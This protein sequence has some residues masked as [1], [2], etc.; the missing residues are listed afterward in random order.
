M[1]AS[2]IAA[3][4][5]VQTGSYVHAEVPN[6]IQEDPKYLDTEDEYNYPLKV[7]C[8]KCGWTECTTSKDCLTK[9]KQQLNLNGKLR[10][11][12]DKWT[13]AALPGDEP[14]WLLFLD[15]GSC[16]KSTSGKIVNIM[17]SPSAF[18]ELEGGLE[19]CDRLFEVDDL[20]DENMKV[21]VQ[22]YAE[23]VKEMKLKKYLKIGAGIAIPTV[24][25][26]TLIAAVA[27]NAN[28]GSVKQKRFA[29]KKS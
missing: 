16:G 4:T 27:S 23:Q 17:I 20:T 22:L 11:C 10:V 14:L 19:V 8:E 13:P 28:N 2:T 1:V 5:C 24:V 21:Y 12:W 7:F 9:V 26:L 6:N 3:V 29:S 25:L 18:V 15:T